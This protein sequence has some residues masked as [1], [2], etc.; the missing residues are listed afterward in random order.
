MPDELLMVSKGQTNL[1]ERFLDAL[2]AGAE[3]VIIVSD[4][5][6]NDPSSAFAPIFRGYRNIGGQAAVLHLNPFFDA[7]TLEVAAL[8][9]DLPAIGLRSSEDLPAL[10]GFAPFF[11]GEATLGQ[12][13][14]YLSAR[15][16]ELLGNSAIK[17]AVNDELNT[18]QD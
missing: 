7:H 9:P 6:E 1:S 8:C 4:A 3:T 16:G 18:V 15:A 12:L 11:S 14:N 10:L 17:E 2:E 5:A 13:E